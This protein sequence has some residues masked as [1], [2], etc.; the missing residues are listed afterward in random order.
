VCVRA[1]ARACVCAQRSSR[2]K[3]EFHFSVETFCCWSVQGNNLGWLNPVLVHLHAACI[4]FTVHTDLKH[5]CIALHFFLTR[6]RC[7]FSSTAM[8]QRRS[9]KL[10]ISI[11]QEFP[12]FVEPESCLLCSRQS[13]IRACPEPSKANQHSHIIFIYDNLPDY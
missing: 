4:H 10:N 9:C 13:A 1:R 12:C 3:E 5:N 8:L 7:R 6:I 2:S 11:G